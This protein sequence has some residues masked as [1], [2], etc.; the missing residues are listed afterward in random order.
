MLKRIIIFCIFVQCLFS[1]IID[2]QPEKSV[3]SNIPLNIELYTDYNRS[4][5]S[6]LNIFYKLHNQDI[7]VKDRLNELSSNYYGYVIPSNFID[8]K[9]VEYYFLIELIDGSF[10]SFPKENP[11]NAPISVRID[12]ILKKMNLEKDYLDADISIISPKNKEKVLSENFMISLS[13]FGMA[14][15]DLENIKIF[16]DDIDVS[17]LSQ[18]RKNNLVY[19]PSKNLKRAVFLY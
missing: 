2:H 18:I 12:N 11:H 5:I 16:V 13:Y 19:I 10:V 14:N 7:Y 4:D 17:S 15:M 9:Y 1:Q 6:T 3:Y 8:G